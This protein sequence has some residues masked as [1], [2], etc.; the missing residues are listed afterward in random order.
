MSSAYSSSSRLN[1]TSSSG[2]LTEGELHDLQVCFDMMDLSGDGNL[3]FAELQNLFR[4]FNLPHSDHDMKAIIQKFDPNGDGMIDF[5]EFVA[6]V[7]DSASKVTEKNELLLAFRTLVPER[8]HETQRGYISRKELL[9]ALSTH[10]HNKMSVAE[11]DTLL[12]ENLTFEQVG[13]DLYFNFEGFLKQL[14]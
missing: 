2:L 10:G 7:S 11:L 3:D 1:K 6:M 5:D 13:S 12:S 14:Q 9:K 8:A 4:C